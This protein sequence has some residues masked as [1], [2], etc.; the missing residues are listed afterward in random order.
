MKVSLSRQASWH[1]LTI[2]LSLC[3]ILIGLRVEKRLTESYDLASR[4]E[5]ADG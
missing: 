2:L 3:E 1:D 5:G 4:Y